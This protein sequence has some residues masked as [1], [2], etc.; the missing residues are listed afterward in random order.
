MA[1]ARVLSVHQRGGTADLHGYGPS[2]HLQVKVQRGRARDLEFEATLFHDGEAMSV[3]SQVVLGW[4]KL[5]K[6]IIALPVAF[7]GVREC[8]G[9]VGKGD[10]GSGNH[11]AFGVIDRAAQRGC[12]ILRQTKRADCKEKSKQL[13]NYTCPNTHRKLLP[14]AGCS[15]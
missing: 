8:R 4:R 2:S 12:G 3:H 7:G 14:A 10:C 11:G 6:L 5:E 15:N 9:W 13:S 1:Q